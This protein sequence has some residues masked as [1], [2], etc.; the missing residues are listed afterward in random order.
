MN[1]RKKFIPN[2]TN[3]RPSR[4]AAI[5]TA[6]FIVCLMMDFPVDQEWFI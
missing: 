4:P 3:K 5:F 2:V 6:S 1:L